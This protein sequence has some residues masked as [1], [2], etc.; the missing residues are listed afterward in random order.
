M[1]PTELGAIESR[2]EAATEPPWVASGVAPGVWL[3]EF[4]GGHERIFSSHARIFSAEDAAFVAF[5]RTDVP[6]P[7]A[8]VRRLRGLLKSAADDN[9]GAVSGHC[10]PNCPWCDGSAGPYP[11]RFCHDELCPAFTENGDVK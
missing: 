7:V 5:A 1:T 10:C 4:S 2:A 3:V 6:A 11:A 8:E 9:E